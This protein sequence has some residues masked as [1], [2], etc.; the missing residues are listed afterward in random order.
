MPWNLRSA[1]SGADTELLRLSGGYLPFAATAQEAAT[2][3]DPRAPVSTRYPRAQDYLQAYTQA[4]D[5]L[6]AEGFLLPEFRD[7][8]LA[9]AR[10]NAAQLP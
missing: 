6:I 10:E 2:R 7:T 5:T 9:I 4:T 3:K 8:L 1:A